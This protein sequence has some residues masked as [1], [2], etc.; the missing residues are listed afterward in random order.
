MMYLLLV[1]CSIWVQKVN[2]DTHGKEATW[3]SSSPGAAPITLIALI[4]VSLLLTAKV[5]LILNYMTEN[6]PFIGDQESKVFNSTLLFKAV[7]PS[8]NGKMEMGRA[9]LFQYKI[10]FIE[11]TRHLIAA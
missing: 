6:L 1:L 11:S 8:L 9:N 3:A 5:Q 7:F 2:N 10:R 4:L